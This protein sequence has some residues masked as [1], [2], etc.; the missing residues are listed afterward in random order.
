MREERRGEKHKIDERKMK[1]SRRRC[2]LT[3]RI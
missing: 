3:R 2:I 1:Y